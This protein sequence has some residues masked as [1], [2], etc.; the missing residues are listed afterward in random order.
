MN[1]VT[2][3]KNLLFVNQESDEMN[4]Q[5]RASQKPRGLQNW[6]YN[7]IALQNMRQTSIKDG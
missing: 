5:K 1:K 7:Y 3:G 2:I 6:S 4:K